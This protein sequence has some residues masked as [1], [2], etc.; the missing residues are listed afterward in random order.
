MSKTN[1]VKTHW[2]KKFNYDYL[3][4]YSLPNGE[5]IV[6]TIKELKDEEVTG[7]GGQKETCLVCYFTDLDKPMILN[8]TNCGSIAKIY[9]S[10]YIEDWVG[11]R[12]QIYAKE[13]VKAFGTTTDALRIREFIPKQRS[14]ADRI[15]ADLRKVLKGCKSLI[16]TTT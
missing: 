7:T 6:G 2:K 16:I 9:G 1:G 10:P 11:N 15:K 8:R 5:D 14:E 3:G 12:V 4:T 13:G